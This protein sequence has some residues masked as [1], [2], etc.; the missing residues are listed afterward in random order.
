MTEP[1]R[2]IDT[3]GLAKLVIKSGSYVYRGDLLG[4]S[5]GWCQA[6]ADTPSMFSQWIA[7]ETVLGDGTK[8]CQVCK[9]ATLEDDDAPYTADAALY[10][11]STAGAITHTRPTTAG[12]LK[13]VVG[14]AIDTYR[15]RIELKTPVEKDLFFPQT[16]GFAVGAAEAGVGIND[17]GFF[18]EGLDANAE[19]AGIPFWLPSNL[20][21][22]DAATLICNSNNASVLSLG[23][24]VARGYP[25]ATHAAGLDTGTAI[26]AG[27]A[28]EADADNQFPT[29]N[30]LACFDADFI[31][32]GAVGGLYLVGTGITGELQVLGLLLRVTL[33][34]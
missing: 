21:S 16:G 5:S 4:Y 2:I 32:P 26:V 19:A 10:L 29:V 11:S 3:E 7:L 13:Q 34:E 28:V 9:K 25:G 8:K 23:V 14:R 27:D 20:I 15:V 17:T 24:T 22:V 6:D 18:G 1:T 33:A 30:V 31:K 12:V